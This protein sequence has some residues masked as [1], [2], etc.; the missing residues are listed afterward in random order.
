MLLKES[1]IREEIK[2]KAKIFSIAEYSKFLVANKKLVF[3]FTFWKDADVPEVRRGK[4][5]MCT[6][7]AVG[8]CA[9]A[10]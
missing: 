4:E 6:V 7:C 1:G 2:P 8:V 3:F 9:R 5:R 10:A